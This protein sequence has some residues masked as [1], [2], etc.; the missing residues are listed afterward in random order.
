M[1]PNVLAGPG[2]FGGMFEVPCGYNKPVLVSS[3]DGVGT[4]LRIASAMGKHDTVGIDIVNHSVN[5][6]LTCGATPLFFLDY[7]A[8]GKLD[9][10]LIA[11]VVKGLSTACQQVGC[12]LIGGETAEMPGLYHGND[13]DLAGFI[14]GI[15]EKDD[16][17]NGQSIKPGDAV[18]GLPSTGLHTNGYSLARRVLGETA[19]AMIM[20]YPILTG[21]VG[22]ALIT[23][24]RS[25]LADLK[26]VLTE[27]KGLAHITGGG[28]TD[29][30]PRTLPPGTAVHITKGAWEVLPIFELIQELGNVADAEMYR[31]FNMGIG[32]VIVAEPAKVPSLLKSMPE[33]KV[34]GEVTADKGLGRVTID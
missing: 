26:P 21:S 10:V 23:P 16:I 15:V 33:A 5:D 1:T 20:R 31:V 18:L 27:I 19:S 2:F 11:E 4:K 12:A 28:F 17:L 6:I 29:N 32:M 34:I 9:P 13:Y 30:I 3:C 24:H 14:V 7:I 25:Y 8:M 22:E